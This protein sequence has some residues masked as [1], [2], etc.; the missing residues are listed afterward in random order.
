MPLQLHHLSGSR[1][2]AAYT[3]TRSVV[4]IGRDRRCDVVLDG[5]NDLIVSNR[6]A[7]ISDVGGRYELRDLSRHGTTING[8]RVAR[9][10]LQDGDVIQLGPSGPR[11]RVSLAADRPADQPSG[12]LARRTQTPARPVEPAPS[13]RRTLTPARPVEPA[14]PRRTPPP[15]RQ[16]A[17]PP[18]VVAEP[19]VRRGP[20]VILAILMSAV[21][22]AGGLAVGFTVAGFLRAAPLVQPTSIVPTVI[23]VPH[24]TRVATLSAAG[25]RAELGRAAVTVPRGAVDG[26]TRI[27]IKRLLGPLPAG[28]PPTTGDSPTALGR[29]YDFGPEGVVFRKPVTVTLGYDEAALPG[30]YSRDGIHLAYFN[31]RS[32]VVA[33]ARVDA[34]RRTV[35]ARLTTF[36]GWAAVP[37]YAKLAAGTAVAAVAWPRTRVEATPGDPVSR[38]T[39]STWI[40]PQDPEVRRRAA[41][42]VLRVEGGDSRPVSD[43]TLGAWL[44]QML[45]TGRPVRLEFGGGPGDTAVHGEHDDGEGSGWQRPR[46][47]FTRGSARGP[48][49]GDCTDM[50]NAAVSVLIASG[51]R[52][53]G[54]VGYA[55]GDKQHVH[56]WAEVVIEGK[57]YHLD[58]AGVI[59]ALDEARRCFP[60]QV[61]S[62]PSDPRYRS[63]WDDKGQATYDPRWAT[64]RGPDGG[65]STVGRD[66]APAARPDDAARSDAGA[67]AARPDAGA[68]AARPD[69]GTPAARP[70]A[71][72]AAP[73]TVR[74]PSTTTVVRARLQAL[75]LPAP[76]DLVS[77]LDDVLQKK[78]ATALD[79][80][81][82]EL[83]KTQGTFYG[84]LAHLK[85]LTLVVSGTS[86]RATFR[87]GASRGD[88]AGELDLASSK[89]TLKGVVH[90][91]GRSDTVRLTGWFTG[92]GYRGTTS[93][94]RILPWMVA[95]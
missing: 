52:A 38:G 87:A 95:R 18:R 15:T 31:G 26:E 33:P 37:I 4:T 8:E 20:R 21:G 51:F 29:A 5:P 65:L 77:H 86:A 49:H 1:A 94:N 28:A 42:A 73:D 45:K 80:A 89:V 35:S 43:L 70:D 32:W 54:V 72:R 6:H 85:R 3:P 91:R 57:T 17:V 90:I 24:E 74:P 76:D 19:R 71:R 9:V 27:V 67:P 61:P 36:R 7:E 11:L 66:A 82:V 39:A 56:A 62:A 48:L 23:D 60:Y 81:L 79:M 16:S 44:E 84:W 55:D 14:S 13:P 47:Y 53:R 78:G 92:D 93:G 40:T 83:G 64:T 41:G 58:E 69:A 22:M 50:T 63:S 46:D 88:F 12:R 59:L 75:R 30:G 10:I 68:P 34:A 2:G 25:G